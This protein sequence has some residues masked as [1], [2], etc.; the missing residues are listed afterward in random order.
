[1]GAVRDMVS[2]AKGQDSP[3][4]ESNA[5]VQDSPEQI[6]KQMLFD[7]FGTLAKDK[8]VQNRNNFKLNKIYYK[9]SYEHGKC[10]E[11]NETKCFGFWKNIRNKFRGQNCDNCGRLLCNKC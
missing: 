2:N 8:Y 4:M 9:T 3:D 10:E 6:M 5:K 1:M 7:R 11:C